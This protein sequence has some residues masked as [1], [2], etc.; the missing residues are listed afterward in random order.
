MLGSDEWP[1]ICDQGVSLGER[2]I[3][4][5]ISGNTLIVEKRQ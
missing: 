4:T 2:V 1:F 5:D 3:V